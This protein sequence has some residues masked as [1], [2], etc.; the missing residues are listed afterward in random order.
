MSSAQFFNM[1]ALFSLETS[2]HVADTA[3]VGHLLMF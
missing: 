1:L 2:L 3:D